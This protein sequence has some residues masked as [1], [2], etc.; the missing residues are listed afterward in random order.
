MDSRNFVSLYSIQQVLL[1]VLGLVMM[2]VVDAD[3][4]V[5]VGMI[6]AMVEV[7]VE[8]HIVVVEVVVAHIVVV[9]AA[10][11]VELA[12][13]GMGLDTV[14][15]SLLAAVDNRTVVEDSM[16]ADIHKAADNNRHSMAADS[17]AVGNTAVD[18]SRHIVVGVGNIVVVEDNSHTLDTHGDEWNLLINAV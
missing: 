11:I 14:H 1:E 9:V 7:V 10:G 13:M 15:S 2:L 4:V 12:L 17:M 18:N 3:I 8:V 16:A 6:L 5:L